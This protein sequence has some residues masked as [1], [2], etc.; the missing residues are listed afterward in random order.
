MNILQLY[1]K[2]LMLI[3]ETYDKQKFDE[4]NVNFAHMNNF[5]E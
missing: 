2:S 5:V 1:H 3:N 4:L